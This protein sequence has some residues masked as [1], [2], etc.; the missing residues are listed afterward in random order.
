MHLR[1]KVSGN[2]KCQHLVNVNAGTC[3][4]VLIRNL[5]HCS[6]SWSHFMP[7]DS[8]VSPA[9]CSNWVSEAQLSAWS[10]FLSRLLLP[11]SLI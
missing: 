4:N 3:I 6:D 7:V 9:R 11:R 1:V 2:G 5:F 10:Q 8:P